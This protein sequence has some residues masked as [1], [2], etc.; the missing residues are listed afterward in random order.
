MLSNSLRISPARVWVFSKS[1]VHAERV[2]A[3]IVSQHV[4]PETHAHRVSGSLGK[5]RG[6][7]KK[8]EV[9]LLITPPKSNIDTQDD[10]VSPF[11]HGYF[12]LFWVSM[13]DF[14]GV[15]K[16]KTT[17]LGDLFGPHETSHHP[18][19]LVAS[20]GP[21]PWLSPVIGG[22]S[23]RSVLLKQVTKLVGGWTNPSEKYYLVKMG[24]SSP[25]F[26]VNIKIFELP[27]PRKSIYIYT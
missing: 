6:S 23:S 25:M 27:P 1:Q 19:S 5:V 16:N 22:L 24:S 9:F 7:R 12:M 8:I 21:W 13:L 4:I 14:R 26:G 15:L 2:F 17:H 3:N 10:G 18:F 20:L 11:K